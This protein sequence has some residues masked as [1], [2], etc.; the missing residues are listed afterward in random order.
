MKKVIPAGW[1]LLFFIVFIPQVEAHEGLLQK[2]DE[3][4]AVT[5]LQQSLINMGYLH[6]N[7]TGYYGPLTYNAVQ[8]FQSDFGL[9][10]DGMTGENTRKKL[11]EVN[12]MAR[13][14]HGEARGEAFKGQV[15]VAAVI[16]NRLQS[17]EF[18]GTVNEVITQKNAFTA[19]QDGQYK[20]EPNQT[21]FRAVKEA[22]NGYD[23]SMGSHYYYNPVLATSDWIWSRTENLQIGKHVFAD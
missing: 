10:V 15:A 13:V 1:A 3:G 2:E 5:E 14:V 12:K 21:A 8:Q 22:W 20:L 19:V 23:P 16:H 9:A 11:T 4:P 18:P 7:A 6:T 17:S